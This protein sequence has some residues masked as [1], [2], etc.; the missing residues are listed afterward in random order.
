[1]ATWIGGFFLLAATLLLMWTSWL[2]KR[3][4][5]VELTRLA[6]SN[7]AFVENLKFPLSPQLASQLSNILDLRVAFFTDEGPAG[8]IP[9]EIIPPIREMAQ[10]DRASSQRFHGIELAVAPLA[11]GRGSLLMI[12]QPNNGPS[13]FEWSFYLPTIGLALGC[14][15]L[16]FGLGRSIVRPLQN[17]TAWLP[18]LHSTS[19]GESDCIPEAISRRPD[20]IGILASSLSDTRDQLLR[21]RELRAR[22]E[23]LAA[24]GRVATSL[25]HEVKN[26]AAAIRMHADLLSGMDLRE[27]AESISLIQEEVDQITNLVNQW[28]FVAKAEPPKTSPRDLRLILEKIAARMRPSLRHLDVSLITENGGDD[29]VLIDADSSRMEQVIR[30][31]IQ[32]AAQAM[33]RGG[34]IFAS[35]KSVGRFA[36]LRILDE[37]PGFSTEAFEHFGEPFFSERE[38]G[39]G[40]GLTLARE[41]VQAHRGTISPERPQSRGAAVSIRIPL[42]ENDRA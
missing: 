30:N 29:P 34:K 3:N 20:E 18:V 24:L 6:R 2:Q 42:S 27:N 8:N 41:V 1:M 19:K 15:A 25:A 36:E 33:P 21:E 26:P 35:V 12:R 38:G 17:L 7:A 23:R 39:M 32:N 4:S 16:A 37:G 11:G 14:A 40:I 9:S 5:L 31:L 10:L 13:L 28:L 22:S